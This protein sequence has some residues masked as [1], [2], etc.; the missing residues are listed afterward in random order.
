MRK[1]IIT[2]VVFGLVLIGPVAVMASDVSDATFYGT[3][4]IT[5]VGAATGVVSVPFTLSTQNLLNKGYVNSNFTNVA[6]RNGAG[7]DVAFMPAQGAGTDWV[8]FV[9]S[10]AQGQ[11]LNDGFYTGGSTA[12]G[13]KIRYFPGDGGM[14]V[15]DDASLE[16]GNDFEL[17][18]KGYIDTSAG[19]DKNI[20]R[21][22]G[23]ISIDASTANTITATI[24]T[25]GTASFRN[26]SDVGPA[27]HNF[28]LAMPGQ[29][30]DIYL[31]VIATR[32]IDDQFA[33]LVPP[34]GWT[35]IDTGTLNTGAAGKHTTALYWKRATGSENSLGEAD[36]T[37]NP[38]S[39]VVYYTIVIAAYQDAAAT[40]NP[41]NVVQSTAHT[42]TTASTT[43]EFGD[44]VTTTQ[45]GCRIILIGVSPGVNESSS[46]TSSPTPEERTEAPN[47]FIQPQ[48]NI[49]DYIQTSAGATGSH[50][51]TYNNSAANNG[52]T[53][54][55]ASEASLTL[56]AANIS[57]G[58]H[59][60]KLTSDGST[61]KLY[62]DGVEKD[63]ENA[64]TIID[65][66]ND[67]VLAENY[68]APYVEH[69]K[70]TVGGVLQGHWYWQ[71]ATTFT[72]QSGNGNTATP[73]FRT[74]TT[75]ADVT[76]MLLSYQAIYNPIYP[77]PIPE[78][79]TS[80]PDEPGFLFTELQFGNVPGAGVINALLDAAN[81]PYA[82]FWFPLIF[83]ISALLGMASFALSK[84]LFVPCVVSSLWLFLNSVPFQI[85]P[86]WVLFPYAVFAV[87]ELVRRR[88][89][90][91]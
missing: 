53:L 66:A 28:P 16:L 19:A 24:T 33:T 10:I 11:I 13:G 87:E 40:G 89:I 41:F 63:S 20:L 62:V 23:A 79:V 69:A 71:N 81:L 15:P 83:M 36:F 32:S 54:A 74:T 1:L 84:D 65:T 18:V 38:P 17:E 70:M 56:T 21:K 43:N 49:A 42:K 64:V 37:Q 80:A 51:A 2:G 34:A 85:V 55:F 26:A 86:A 47:G 67:W 77:V 59:T 3:L 72:D 14:T 82:I 27:V 58:E 44:G 9:D 75:D 88:F 68:S 4:K 8:V 90:S 50:S 78:P 52:Y 61:V 48:V 30:G 6:I 57:S 29:A 76:A 5:N 45:D 60:V 91:V 22:D 46:Y 31:M 12:M 7:T 35:A 25:S 73:T 39:S